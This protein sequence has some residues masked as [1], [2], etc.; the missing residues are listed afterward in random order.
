MASPDF[1]NPL[2]HET[3]PYK[4]DGFVTGSIILPGLEMPLTLSPQQ[5]FKFDG[6]VPDMWK[7]LKSL[8]PDMRYYTDKFIGDPR[9]R[10]AFNSGL[11]WKDYLGMFM[12]VKDVSPR[13]NLSNVAHEAAEIV[14]RFGYAAKLEEFLRDF[15]LKKTIVWSD[16]HT[17]G[18]IA[19]ILI[20]K[21][22]DLDMTSLYSDQ[23][24]ET[25]AKII[26]EG[27]I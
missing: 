13:V 6:V 23:D 8:S 24:P 9:F 21:S 25:Y 11:V 10:T 22:K 17:V 27:Y 5:Y 19:G 12:A 4:D 14:Y 15:G 26:S 3:P 2:K 18:A 16:S 7:Y 20:P 1:F